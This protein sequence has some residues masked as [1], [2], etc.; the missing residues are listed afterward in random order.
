MPESGVINLLLPGLILVPMLIVMDG[1][2]AAVNLGVTW[3]RSAFRR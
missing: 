3:I 2:F 1:L